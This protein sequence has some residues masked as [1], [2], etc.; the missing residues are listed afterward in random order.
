MHFLVSDS[1]MA[2]NIRKYRKSCNLADLYEEDGDYRRL[3]FDLWC[4]QGLPW[5]FHLHMVSFAIRMLPFF[6]DMKCFLIG[7]FTGGWYTVSKTFSKKH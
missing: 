4:V 2:E 5:Q 6:C 7:V 1:H 3:E